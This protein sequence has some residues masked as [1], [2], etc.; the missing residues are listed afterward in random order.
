MSRC[1]MAGLPSQGL[2][3]GL[4]PATSVGL[5]SSPRCRRPRRFASTAR[6]SPYNVAAIGVPCGIS[7]H[8]EE[9]G[10]AG[11]LGLA[12][13]LQRHPESPDRG[14]KANARVSRM[15]GS[16]FEADVHPVG[17]GT[18]DADFPSR[19]RPARPD[20][21]TP[22]EP[23]SPQRRISV[24]QAPGP[25]AAR[26]DRGRLVHHRATWARGETGFPAL[27]AHLAPARHP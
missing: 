24:A 13:A 3:V 2:R 11:P 20:R 6:E 12:R 15:Q 10:L 26:C 25:I 7:I 9:T 16:A 23:F 22:S 19:T 14:R 8:H 1:L 4:R 21:G 18:S 27:G 5:P 17:H